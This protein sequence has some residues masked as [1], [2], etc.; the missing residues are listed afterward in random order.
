MNFEIIDLKKYERFINE[1]QDLLNNF[2]D[3]T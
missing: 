2:E 1:F 3:L